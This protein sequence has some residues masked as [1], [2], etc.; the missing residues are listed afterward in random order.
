MR[1]NGLAL[2]VCAWLVAAPAGAAS[3][4]LVLPLGRVAYQT[5]E[6]IDVA[7]VRSDP[8]ALA[9]GALTLTLTGADGSVVHCVFP[10]RAAAA[11]GGEARATE[12]LHLDGRLLRPGAYTLAVAADGASVQTP[13]EVYGHVR[14]SSYRLVAWGSRAKDAEQ[15]LLGEDGLGFNLLYAAAKG[16]HSIR[17]GLDYTGACVMSGAHQMDIRSECD[18]SDPHVLG[19]GTARVVRAALEFRTSPNAVGVHCYDEPG[20]TWWKDPVTGEMTAHS[21][22]AQTR[23]YQSAFG[24]EPLRYTDLRPDNPEHAARWR[25]WATWKLGFMDAAWRDAQFGVSWVRPD[26]LTLTQSQYGFSAFTDG[27]YFN[28]SRCLPVAS[29]HGGYDDWGPGYFNPSYTLEIA[30]ARDLARPCWYLPC[31]YGNTPSERFRL[32]QHLSFMTNIQGLCTPPDLQVHKPESCAAAEG[33]VE[34]NKAMARLGTIFTTM[35]VTRPPVALLFSLSNLLAAQIQDTK[36]YYA[37][38]TRHGRNLPLAYLAGKVLGQQF[39]TVVDE[40]VVDGTLAANHR[41]V[42]LTSVDHL[43]PEV[44]AG[45]EAFAAQGGLVLVTGDSPVRVKGAVDLGVTPAMPDAAL[46]ARLAAEKRNNEMAPYLTTGKWL[47][48]ASAL[49]QAIAPHLARVGITPPLVS[50]NPAIVVTRQAGGDLEYL[51]AV[52]AAYD[53]TEGKLNSI[54]AT[55]ATLALPAD[56][57]PVYD[58]LQ[59]RP[60]RFVAH[61]RA[62]TARVRFGP[63]Q[64]RVFARAARPIGG[65]RVAAP[66]VSSDT[67]AADSPLHVE[68]SALLVDTAGGVLSGSAPLAIQ[69]IDPAG[70]LR[71]D[72]YRATRLGVC[73]LRLPLAVNDPPGAWQVVVTDLLAGTT[74]RAGFTLRTPG[75]VG[76]LAGAT[77]RAVVFG[78]DAANIF[79][80]VRVHRAVTI[81]AG[82]SDYV[83]PAAERLAAILKP[84]KVTCRLVPA[85]EAAKSRTLSEEEAKTWCGMT[86]AGRGQIKPGGG[87][88]PVLSGFAVDGPAI[89]LG[90]PEDNPLIKFALDQKMLPYTPG[91]DFPGRGRGL[92]AWQ[93]DAVGQLQES[94]TAIGYDAE[95]LA[96]AVG[97]LY[98]A[99]AGLEPL[100]PLALPTSCTVTPASRTAPLPAA[101]IVWATPLADRAVRLEA[102]AAGQ[103]LGVTLDGSATT[104]DA[105][106]RIVAQRPATP[107]EL[108]PAKLARDLPAPLRQKT[109]AQRVVKAAATA[110]GRVALAYWGGT[111]QV[112]DTATGALLCQQLLPQDIT[113]V[114]W[115]GELCVVGLADGRLLG[116]RVPPG[117]K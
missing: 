31:W 103:V 115:C 100:T 74:G 93:L 55:S 1:R 107:A 76:A 79:R 10:V 12:H 72:L 89:L 104:V 62:L 2:W 37:H 116:L 61:G 60:A 71:H 88:P 7:V 23:S 51:F 40:D 97:T 69:V 73:A 48:G 95:G 11:Q 30:R 20:L 105:A 39:L 13:L 54:R 102:N 6:R 75:P 49:A 50:D 38:E 110:G 63:G 16:D 59:S 53:A 44:V 24:A 108:V 113:R 77:R 42:L 70:G 5:N 65:V 90:T 43:A 46:L 33:I 78:N 56:G 85:A 64:M 26:Y 4:R 82:K 34:S 3:L 14:R 67:T 8:Q 41:A 17:G 98:E 58:A 94:V 68:L 32:E 15:A 87:N 19:G 86:Y 66:L 117:G 21:V 25:Q 9:A 47:Q 111:L 80:F 57:R 114:A 106:G 22:P 81:V 91:P 92:V 29:G 83:Q 27:Y 18:W 52:N 45:L 112:C 35:P 109:L 101:T 99:A 28:V 96:E 84:W 36:V